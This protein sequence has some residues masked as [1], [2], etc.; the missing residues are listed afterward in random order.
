MADLAVAITPAV[1]E[2]ERLRHERL[3]KERLN[4]DSPVVNR[5]KTSTLLVI[6]QETAGKDW[7]GLTP[8]QKDELV[9]A[10]YAGGWEFDVNARGDVLAVT[11][12]GEDE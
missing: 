12:V 9:D 10:L 5:V 3:Y 2:R 11:K 7:N 1:I 6:W 4:S 8:R